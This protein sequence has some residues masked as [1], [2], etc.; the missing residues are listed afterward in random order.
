MLLLNLVTIFALVLLFV[1]SR[2]IVLDF[3]LPEG[4]GKP[5]PLAQAVDV[6]CSFLARALIAQSKGFLMGLQSGQQRAEKA[7]KGDIAEGI[8]SQNPLGALLMSFPALKKTLRRNPALLDMALGNL[9]NNQ[10]NV[11]GGNG[12]NSPKFN[13]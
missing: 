5:S 6:A 2:R 10:M 9:S 8:V 11:P 7:V 12:E 3:I 4:E 1:K 13:L